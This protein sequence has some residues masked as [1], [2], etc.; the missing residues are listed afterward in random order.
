MAAGEDVAADEVVGGG[1]RVVALL[2]PK[3]SQRIGI[4]FGESGD[5]GGVRWEDVGV[6]SQ[7]GT[8][9]LRHGDTLEDG[10]STILLE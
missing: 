8:H 6:V 7:G 1:V 3:V 2:R 5:G 10:N 4:R 9:C